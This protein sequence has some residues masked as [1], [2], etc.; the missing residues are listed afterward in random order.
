M[1]NLRFI[2]IAV[3]IFS[4]AFKC[5]P[6]AGPNCHSQAIGAIPKTSDC[7]EYISA[8]RASWGDRYGK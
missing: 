6:G 4:C 7:N 1:K 2:L 5:N 8:F 3:F